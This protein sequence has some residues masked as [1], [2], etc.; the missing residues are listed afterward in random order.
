MFEVPLGVG[1]CSC[2]CW[3]GTPFFGCCCPLW[4]L[5]KC[6]GCGVP[7]KQVMDMDMG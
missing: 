6:S 1:I 4:L 2:L 5:G 7:R 3:V